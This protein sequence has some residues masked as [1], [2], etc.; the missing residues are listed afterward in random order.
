MSCP[1]CAKETDPQFKPFCSAR[2]RD[3]D[4]HR[5][6]TGSYAVPAVELDDVDMNEL[7]KAMDAETP[8]ESPDS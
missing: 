2:C 5:W 3:H 1:I 4:L 6:F 7:D 8:E